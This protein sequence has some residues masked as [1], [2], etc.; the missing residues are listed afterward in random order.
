MSYRCRARKSVTDGC[1][2]QESL[3]SDLGPRLEPTHAHSL[4][5]QAH[6]PSPD[7]L[8]RLLAWPPPPPRRPT[9]PRPPPRPPRPLRLLW[10]PPTPASTHHSGRVKAFSVAVL[11]HHLHRRHTTR[12]PE[13]HCGHIRGQVAS[14]YQFV[15]TEGNSLHCSLSSCALTKARQPT[16]PDHKELSV[17]GLL[18]LPRRRHTSR[19]LGHHGCHMSGHGLQ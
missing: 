5:S 12:M 14:T 2:C 18:R 10:P 19:T 16:I 7:N 17:H 6:H 11:L 1:C 15:V 3:P 4:H 13:L 9:P 8:P